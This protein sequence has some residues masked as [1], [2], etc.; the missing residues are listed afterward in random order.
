MIKGPSDEKGG[1]FTK[2]IF[3]IKTAR[4]KITEASYPLYSLQI[5]QNVGKI[6]PEFVLLNISLLL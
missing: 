6:L 3:T 1:G 4:L 2:H 5:I